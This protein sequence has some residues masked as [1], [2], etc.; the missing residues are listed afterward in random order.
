MKARVL[1]FICVI[2]LDHFCFHFDIKSSFSVDKSQKSHVKS[3]LIHCCE[4]S[5][6]TR[7]LPREINTF[8]RHH[9][10]WVWIIDLSCT[11][12]SLSYVYSLCVH[13]FLLLSSAALQGPARE[14][15]SPRTHQWKAAKGGDFCMKNCHHL[16]FQLHFQ[17]GQP[18]QLRTNLPTHHGEASHRPGEAQADQHQGDCGSGEC[19]GAE[20]GLQSSPALH[21]GERQEHCNTQGLLLCPGSHCERSP[22]GEM[23][24]NT[25]VL[26]W[27]RPQ[28]K[29]QSFN[30]KLNSLHTVNT[31]TSYTSW[32][33][34][35]TFT[36]EKIFHVKLE[37]RV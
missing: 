23:D 30:V 13:L 3:T 11:N 12:P 22:G 2:N 14:T 18:Q 29:D 4:A 8:Y 24:Q 5:N 17:P 25:T 15:P 34:R 21:P 1:Y 32:Q 9:D 28:G 20:E 26:L 6:K 10:L 37:A 33:I 31:D 7:K 19:S 16:T 36:A 27:S 35:E